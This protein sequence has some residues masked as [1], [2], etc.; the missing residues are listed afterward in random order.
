MPVI[1]DSASIIRCCNKV[2]AQTRFS[3]LGIPTPTTLIITA[4]TPIDAIEAAIAYPIVLKTPDGSFSRS[5]IKVEN[6]ADLLVNRAIMCTPSH[7]ILAQE[8][9]PTAFD[10]R[11]G[12]LAGEPLFACQYRM[13]RG[14]W[15]IIRHYGERRSVAGRVTAVPLAEVPRDVLT[16]ALR[17]SQAMGSGLYGVDL[18]QTAK[19]PLV[20]E[21][22]DN[23][24]IRHGLED[25]AEGD[26]VWLRILSWYRLAQM[27][28][29]MRP[30]LPPRSAPRRRRA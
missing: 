24:D 18:K 22:N 15:Q 19:G 3:H 4:E 21:V 26:A 11:I 29:L 23:P 1:D 27:K 12:V 25:G 5:V 8:F 28:G 16:V 7:F 6:R 13:A 2:F 10:W 9:L 20:I 30:A 14:H 17:A